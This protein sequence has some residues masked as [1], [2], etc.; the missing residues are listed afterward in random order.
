MDFH[1]RL[2]VIK[3][4]CCCFSS[5]S[6]AWRVNCEIKPLP[7]CLR[8]S[9]FAQFSQSSSAA[10]LH[11]A[12]RDIFLIVLP[13]VMQSEWKNLC[14][15]VQDNRNAYSMPR[16]TR[17][18]QELQIW[19]NIWGSKV[20][21]PHRF[22]IQIEGLMFSL[23]PQ[24]PCKRLCCN[25]HTFVNFTG[26]LKIVSCLLARLLYCHGWN[27]STAAMGENNVTY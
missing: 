4:C 24:L 13:R 16:P 21:C 14:V 12:R 5:D 3:V 17:P 26:R 25:Q 7:N 20:Q 1:Y 18:W 22:T 11:C 10:H 9:P 15:C 27:V 2:W 6:S 19:K 8:S 23:L